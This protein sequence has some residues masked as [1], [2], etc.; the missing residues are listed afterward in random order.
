MYLETHPTS[1]NGY[2]TRDLLTLVG[3]LEDLK[4][5]RVRE[6]HLRGPSPRASMPRSISRWDLALHPSRKDGQG[7]RAHGSRNQARWTKVQRVRIFI[8]D[9]LPR[10]RL[11]RI[12]TPGL[13]HLEAHG[14]C[15]PSHLKHGQVTTRSEGRA[16]MVSFRNSSKT[17]VLVWCTKLPTTPTYN[18]S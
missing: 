17:L 14:K 9:N 6:G 8:T 16:V 5:P 15:G 10:L 4:V 12:S 1:A 2:Y 7:T 3:P 13:A 18:F 11:P